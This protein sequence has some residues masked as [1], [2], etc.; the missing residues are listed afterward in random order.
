[1]NKPDFSKLD[2]AAISGK[3][4]EAVEKIEELVNASRINELLASVKTVESLLQ[5]DAAKEAAPKK[6]FAPDKGGD[7]KKTL[8]YVLAA[9]GAIV[10]IALVA[11]AVY[12]FFTPDYMEDLDDEDIFYDETEDGEDDPEDDFIKEK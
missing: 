3:S 10:V 2:L 12:K 7:K 6:T 4:R 9:I 5:K 11:Y 1:M 8:Y